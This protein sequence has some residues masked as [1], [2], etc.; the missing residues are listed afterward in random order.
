MSFHH[1]S[2]VPIYDFA[3]GAVT[4]SPRDLKLSVQKALKPILYASD[5]H[6]ALMPL[7]GTPFRVYGNFGTVADG[8]ALVS[9]D[10]GLALGNGQIPADTILYTVGVA[11]QLATAPLAWRTLN[12]RYIQSVAAAPFGFSLGSIGMMPKKMPWCC[13]FPSSLNQ[14]LTKHEQELL[15]IVI[16]I[17]S[18]TTLTECEAGVRLSLEAG[19]CPN[20]DP[21]R[22]IELQDWD[23]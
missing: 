17:V 11:C 2:T 9:I 22:F 3:S 13:G 4:Q 7:D 5:K 6:K 21:E 20:V 16:Q 15:G 18:V 12:N 1:H 10:T 19:K 23:Q 14:K 8:N